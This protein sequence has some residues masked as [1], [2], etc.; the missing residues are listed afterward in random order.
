M[1]K[2]REKLGLFIDRANRLELVVDGA[3]QNIDDI[4]VE[5]KK[6]HTVFIQYTQSYLELFFN[7]AEKQKIYNKLDLTSIK[8]S[9]GA[10][11]SGNTPEN[12]LFGVIEMLT[13][14]HE[15]G[16]TEKVMQTIN[17]SEHDV[18]IIVDAKTDFFE[19]LKLK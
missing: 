11:L 12:H 18:E 8:T 5:E 6:W 2:G 13:F 10:R 3:V 15:T 19:Y 9:I 14:G 16:P 4:F 7:Q 1:G 17:G